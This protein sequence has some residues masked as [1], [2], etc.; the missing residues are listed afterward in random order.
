LG[1][2]K[3]GKVVPSRGE[4]PDS[5]SIPAKLASLLPKMMSIE[6]ITWGRNY[7]ESYYGD[8]E[9]THTEVKDR[10]KGRG[11]IKLEDRARAVVASAGGGAFDQNLT[12]ALRALWNVSG[13]IRPGGIFILVAECRGGLGSRALDRYVSG[14]ITLETLSVGDQ[15]L[16]GAEDLIFLSEIAKTLKIVLIS[17]LPNYYVETVLGLRVAK[18]LRDAVDYALSSG[19]SRIKLDVLYNASTTL[20]KIR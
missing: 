18:R 13:F 12:T 14:R 16:D 6:V 20:L 1:L 3:L 11:I 19:G 5:A 2:K 8:A 17:S 4:E 10:L 15:Y 7:A 9:D